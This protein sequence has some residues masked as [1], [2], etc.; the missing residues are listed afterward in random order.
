MSIPL[1]QQY[2]DMDPIHVPN[3]YVNGEETSK[4]C[5]EDIR[6]LLRWI[7]D[8]VNALHSAF[9]G[10]S[11]LQAMNR[12]VRRVLRKYNTDFIFSQNVRHADR[13]WHN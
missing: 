10:D 2:V 3:P 7:K 1:Q 9:S 6:E 12:N 4:D 11:Q 8:H 5:H 13:T